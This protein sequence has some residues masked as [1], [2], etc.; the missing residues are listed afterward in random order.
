MALAQLAA[1]GLSGLRHGQSRRHAPTAN[2]SNRKNWTHNHHNG[3]ETPGHLKVVSH[4]GTAV[5][6]GRIQCVDG[7]MGQS[8]GTRPGKFQSVDEQGWCLF[9]LIWWPWTGSRNLISRSNW[10]TR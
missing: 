6:I 7:G 1:A 9:N 10:G 8:T 3:R 2:R 5:L 4:K